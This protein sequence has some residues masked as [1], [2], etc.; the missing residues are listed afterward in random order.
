MNYLIS[1]NNGLI[2]CLA[3]GLGP[4]I[5][6]LFWHMIQMTKWQLLLFR[7]FSFQAVLELTIKNMIHEVALNKKTIQLSNHLFPKDLSELIW[8]TLQYTIFF[9]LLYKTKASS[10][11]RKGYI[12]WYFHTFLVHKF[13]IKWRLCHLNILHTW[14]VIRY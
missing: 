9:L 1:F 3:R 13:F 6:V 14:L 8:L 12:H 2:L 7:F 10:Q 11:T 4:L 5:L